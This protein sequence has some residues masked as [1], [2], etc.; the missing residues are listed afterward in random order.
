MEEYGMAN[1]TLSGYKPKI[2]QVSFSGSASKPVTAMTDDEL[3]EALKKSK[4]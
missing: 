2:P 4:P 1:N 3:L